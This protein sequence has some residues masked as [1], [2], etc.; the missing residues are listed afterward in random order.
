MESIILQNL[1]KFNSDIFFFFSEEHTFTDAEEYFPK[2]IKELV[3][4][5]LVAY[6]ENYDKQLC[7]AKAERKEQ[8]LV[9]ERKNDIR[10][11]YTVFG[12]I[13]Y[14]RT[15]F[16]NKKDEEY[17]YPLDDFMDV[18]ARER[19]SHTVM[20]NLLNSATKRSYQESVNLVT[21]GNISKQT[22]MNGIRRSY[23]C[24]SETDFKRKIDVLHV[25]ADEDHVNLQTGKS[26]I[27]P[28]VCTYEGIERNGKRG[29]CI[30]RIDISEYGLTPD[31]LWDEVSDRID[32][33]YILDNTKIYVHGDGASWIKKALDYLPNA[34][35]VLDPYHKNKYIKASTA[36]MKIE[37]CR[38]FEE[39]IR[40]SIYEGDKDELICIQ[41]EM[42][43]AY[44]ER[45]ENIL[46][47]TGYLI[48][49][50]ESMHIRYIDPEA[51]NGGATEPHVSHIL[52]SRFSSRPKGW[53]EET[54]THFAPMVA[55][56]TFDFTRDNP[57]QTVEIGIKP[58][59]KPK[60]TRYQP[61]TL[62]L[63]DPDISVSNPIVYQNTGTYKAL[64]PFFS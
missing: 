6:A 61:G 12:K 20:K 35:Y 40:K 51:K 60:K 48:S 22:V 27:L 58:L 1:E 63:S 15:Y 30:N 25:D 62:G 14:K 5:L 47:T 11:I 26:S 32:G 23:V 38:K 41:G 9:I 56:S 10:S 16:R 34:V 18:E 4:Q 55:A 29:T 31:E 33:R 52:S 37:D 21:D 45:Y 49:N 3:R 7:E 59:A 42:I 54:L 13:D 8:G 64:K 19:V 24:Y 53:S 36:G 57:C 43:D 17:C 50:F 28:L 39:R 46:E 2:R 44:P